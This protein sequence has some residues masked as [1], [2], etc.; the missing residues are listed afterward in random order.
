MYTCIYVTPVSNER[1][2]IKDLVVLTE[3]RWSKPETS[4][5]ENRGIYVLSV[6][7]MSC[8]AAAAAGAGVLPITP[9]LFDPSSS[10]KLG[11]NNGLA[12]TPQMGYV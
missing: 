6:W 12:R 10:T 3:V 1:W 11:L 5:M 8:V 9:P 4:S 7:V 2:K